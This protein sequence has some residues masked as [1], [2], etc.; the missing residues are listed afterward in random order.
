MLNYVLAI[1][2][3]TT[4]ITILVFD[5]GQKIVARFY[6]EI[7][8]YYP[9]PG[10]VEHDAEEIWKKTLTGIKKILKKIPASE[11]AAVGITNQRETVVAWDKETGKPYGK[12]IV[13]QCR[14]TSDLCKKLKKKGWEGKIRKKTG[15]LLDPY[16]SATKMKWLIEAHKLE[17]KKN[18]IVGTIDSWL[19]WKLTQ[20]KVHATDYTN[21]SRTMLFNIH[22]L[23]WDDE[24]CALFNVDQRMLPSAKPP[25]S[26]FGYAELCGSKIPIAGMM[27]DQQAATF[28]QAC[29]EKGDVK[30]TYG[31]GCFI[32]MNT[33]AKAVLS[34]NRLLTTIAY[35]L[36]GKVF[37]ALEGSVFIG[38]A[39]VQWLRDGL[40]VIQTSKDV[41]RLIQKVKDTHGV[42]FVPAFVGL[43][44]PYWDTEARGIISGITRGTTQEHIARAAVES[45]AYQTRDVIEAMQ[46]DSRLKIKSLKVDGG[47]SQNNFLMQF[48]SDILGA[49][50]ERPAIHETTAL[51]A[52]FVAGLAAG[53]WK[54]ISEL[55]KQRKGDALFSPKMNSGKR[56]ELYTCWKDAVSRS[57]SQ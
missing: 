41:E 13:W 29:F 9:H 21:A 16:F 55:R 43:G 30:N 40:R 10:W 1:D 36:D 50:I 53:F 49:R 48:Q 15:L 6:E 2:E 3:G 32:L 47:A 22:A 11:I 57:L 28:G 5:R 18:C 12:A 25:S 46:K 38:G 45:I 26:L 33:G 27:G 20:G 24:L 4:G 8:Q 14:R 34:K 56:D 51:G 7:T 19:L 54:N 37:Y 23:Q 44:A 39:V 17:R 52:A 42:Y 35:A 31:T